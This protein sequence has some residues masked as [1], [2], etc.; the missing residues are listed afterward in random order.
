MNNDPMNRGD[1]KDSDPVFL[2]KDSDPMIRKT[3]HV[4]ASD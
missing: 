3:Q 4:P 1:F 2:I